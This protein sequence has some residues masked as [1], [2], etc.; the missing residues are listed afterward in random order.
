MWPCRFCGKNGCVNTNHMTRTYC[1][2]CK[3]QTYHQEVY[4]PPYRLGQE[5]ICYECG[6]ARM[7]TIQG[8]DAALM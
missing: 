4:D 1:S 2:Y 3:R 8:F 5:L 7:K 6:S